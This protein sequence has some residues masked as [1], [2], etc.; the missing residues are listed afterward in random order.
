MI[1]SFRLDETCK[2][3]GTIARHM[4]FLPI[5]LIVV[6]FFNIIKCPRGEHP[7]GEDQ[8]YFSP[9]G[10]DQLQSRSPTNTVMMNSTTSPSTT[11][12]L[13]ERAMEEVYGDWDITIGA[14]ELRSWQPRPMP[15]SE[16]GDS[17]WSGQR[18]YLWTDLRPR[19]DRSY[20]MCS[21]PE[22]SRTIYLCSSPEDFMD[23]SITS[24]GEE[25][26]GGGTRKS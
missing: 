20:M 5:A 3:I 2:H 4:Q 9:S 24:S 26:V 19:H 11:V 13:L 14:G 8:I 15:A 25:H 12:D 22:D 10:T 21:S 6:G 17:E 23:L 7:R 16:A 1:G 18:R